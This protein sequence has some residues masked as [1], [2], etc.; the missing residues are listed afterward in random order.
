MSCVTRE[1]TL[2]LDRD[3][4]WE[5]VA[6]LEGWLAE[7]AEMD[8]RPGGDGRLRLAD[9]SERRAV[10]ED[11]REGERLSWWWFSDDPADL[12]THVELRLEDAVSGTRVIVVESGYAPGPAARALAR[13]RAYA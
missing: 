1:I 12:G 7:E 5:E 8:L 9:G 6:D 13:P 3:D 10:V 11:V 2:P 4:A